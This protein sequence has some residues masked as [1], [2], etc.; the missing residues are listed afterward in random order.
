MYY[1]RLAVRDANRNDGPF[2]QVY[3]FTKQYPAPTLVAPLSGA[4][5]GDYPEFEWEAITGAAYYRLMVSTN[6]QFSS[7]VLDVTTSNIHF[8]PTNKLNTG[9]YY[10]RVAM[11]DKDGRQG[12]FN[13]ATLIVDPYPYRVYMPLVIK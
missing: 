13:D 11:V 10:W 5:T 8:I 7:P 1:W 12:P 4:R 6:P 3:T 9:S 2:T